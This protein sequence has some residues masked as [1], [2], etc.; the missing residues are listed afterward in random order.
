MRNPTDTL[1]PEFVVT[2][3]DKPNVAGR[4]GVFFDP[5]NPHARDLFP[6]GS[7]RSHTLVFGPTLGFGAS[8]GRAGM[9]I[10]CI[11]PD[12]DAGVAAHVAALQL[13]SRTE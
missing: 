1:Y 12:H 8:Q 6:E 13:A 10:R 3:V 2:A 4:P 5:C 11:G 7:S 9:P